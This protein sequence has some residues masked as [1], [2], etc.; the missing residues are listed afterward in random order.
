M[1]QTW[2]A[3]KSNNTVTDLV[4]AAANSGHIRVLLDANAD[5]HAEDSKLYTPLLYSSRWGCVDG[6]KLLCDAKADV[7]HVL[8]DGRTC[9][10]N[11][12]KIGSLDCVKLL[13]EFMVSK[14]PSLI[15]G[16]SM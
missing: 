9:L 11:A 8:A 16:L 4:P 5:I 15:S 7:S 14:T 13:L 2:V 6:V 3:L 1:M 12:S 10:H